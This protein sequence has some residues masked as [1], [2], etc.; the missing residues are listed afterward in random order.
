MRA[1]SPPL[2]PAQHRYADEHACTFDYKSVEREQL[3]AA[4]K[5]VVGAKVDFL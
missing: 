1:P 2:P 4:N 3:A 5:R